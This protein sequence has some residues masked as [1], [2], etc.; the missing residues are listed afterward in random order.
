LKRIHQLQESVSA[1]DTLELETR[2]IIRGPDQVCFD[3]P[4]DGQTDR[5]PLTAIKI[6]HTPRHEAMGGKVHDME[7][8][9]IQPAMLPDD[10]EVH[11]MARRTA[12]FGYGQL[13][14]DH[15]MLCLG[16]LVRSQAY[17]ELAKIG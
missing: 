14:S 17:P 3:S 11:G 7:V 13:G 4:D 2:A 5:N 6:G 15:N 16:C 9:I 12:H 8:E 10:S 1:Q